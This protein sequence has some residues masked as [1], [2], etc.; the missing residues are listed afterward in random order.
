M[1][2]LIVDDYADIRETLC[3]ILQEA[4]YEVATADDGLDALN[5]LEQISPDLIIMDMM[6]PRMD[7]FQFVRE[8]RR[9]APFANVPVIAVTARDVEREGL[10]G[11]DVQASLPKPFDLDE[12]L[13]TVGR[14][15]PAN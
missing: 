9:L 1:P 11:L 10:I 14:L 6:M 2:I 4:G 12:L 13:E 15:L 8:L 3:Y 7:G 5:K